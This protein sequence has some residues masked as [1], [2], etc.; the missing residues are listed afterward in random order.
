V[1]RMSSLATRAFV[2]SFIP[3]CVVLAIGFFALTA[4]M[5]RHVR[6]GLRESIEKSQNLLQRAHR[7][8]TLQIAQFAA[9][10]ADSA[11][12]KSAIQLAHE[13]SASPEGASMARRTI[14]AQLSE[15]HKLV[16]YDLLAVTDWKG[17]TLGALEIRAGDAKSPREMPAFSDP[18][19]LMEFEGV[20][21]DLST[22]P[23][24]I[25][26]GEQIGA[27]QLG[28]Q[29]DIARYQAGGDAALMH[30]GHI[31]FATF[32]KS[33]WS[34]LETRLGAQ[35][36]RSDAECEIS[37]SRGTLLVLPVQEEGIGAGYRLLEFRSLSQA[38]REFT[39]GWPAVLVEVGAGGVLL[40]LFSTLMTSR[41][42]S[43]PLRDLVSQLR[44]GERDS[45]IPETVT[46]EKAAGEIRV[47]ADAFNRTAAAAQKS[48]NELQGA[49]I[50]AE[51]ANRAK[52]EFIAN[53]SHELRT[54]MNGVIGMTELLLTTEL[55]E[56]QRD[57]AITVRESADGLMGIINDILDFTRIDAGKLTIRRAPCDLR[58][59]ISEV[60]GLLSVRA[61]GKG[62]RLGLVYPTAVPSEVVADAMRIRQVLMN[63]V[64]NAI[65][66]TE[67]GSVEI[68]ADWQKSS[69]KSSPAEGILTLSVKDTGIGIPADKLD[70]IFEKFTQVDGSMTRTYGGTGLGLTIVR[71][72]T[73]LMGGTVSVESRLGEGSTFRVALPMTLGG[74]PTDGEPA[75]AT[76]GEPDRAKEEA[77]C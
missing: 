49:K 62:L 67:A 12:L 33:Q 5:E 68:R 25:E 4:A 30:D 73:E 21:Y 3:V 77:A 59:T 7:E 22:V 24:S 1:K 8:S 75:R 34:E 13:N 55:D 42:V 19:S 10:M 69:Q 57:Y 36:A 56:E 26:A 18:P 60:T 64:G 28:R 44:H 65:K 50:A 38:V 43:K 27:L 41:S 51:S 17:Q 31:L 29:F 61:S 46:V 16:G 15:I 23:V 20:L 66:F 40:A 63:L 71:Q 35:C 48:W 72:L 54:P 2:F 32:A 37:T 52:T 74:T 6:T 14:E 58:Q 70:A 53:M 9:G 39:A 76:D 45:H 47:L 11:G